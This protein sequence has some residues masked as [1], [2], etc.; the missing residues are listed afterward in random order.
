MLVQSKWYYSVAEFEVDYD[1]SWDGRRIKYFW[2][3]NVG[4]IK[5]EQYMN[6]TEEFLQ[7]WELI[8]HQVIQ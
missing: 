7:S 3:K 6:F 5:R 1:P 2:A 4:L 8:D